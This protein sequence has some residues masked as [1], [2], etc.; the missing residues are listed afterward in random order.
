MK[1]NKLKISFL[2]KI[3]TASKEARCRVVIKKRLGFPM[4]FEI[5][6]RCPELEIGRNSVAAWIIAKRIS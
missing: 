5:K 3:K 1:L 4:R 2:V 6:A